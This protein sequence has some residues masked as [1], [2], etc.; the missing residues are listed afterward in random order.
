MSKA[1]NTLT[2]SSHSSV[3][4]SP[5]NPLN[6]LGD[7]THINTL[8][9]RTLDNRKLF[10]NINTMLYPVFELR[11]FEDRCKAYG[12]TDES[13]FLNTKYC[14]ESGRVTT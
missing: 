14:R 7:Y 8:K 12:I 6:A 3:S 13:L 11:L 2:R 5:E 1:Q 10:A 9:R 4:R